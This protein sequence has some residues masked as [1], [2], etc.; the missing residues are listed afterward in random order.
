M[1][2]AVIFDFGQVLSNFDHMRACRRLAKYSGYTAEEIYTKIFDS[3]W[4]E[5]G[6]FNESSLNTLHDAGKVSKDKFFEEVRRKIVSRIGRSSLTPP[7]LMNIWGDIFKPNHGIEELLSL[8]RPEV[9]T[10]VLSNM[11]PPHWEFVKELS[12]VRQH[13]SDETRVV[14]SYLVGAQKP[15]QRMYD[16]AFKCLQ[17]QG[18]GG[19]VGSVVFIDDILAY[20]QAFVQLGGKTIAYNCA[21]DSLQVL[22]DGLRLHGL[23]K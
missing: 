3:Q 19:D 23:L 12:V 6:V 10:C 21:T 5:S 8:L 22:E 14:R 11:S 17:E 1:D 4:F 2:Q 20:R 7:L 18:W 9:P 13:F 16:T 15:D